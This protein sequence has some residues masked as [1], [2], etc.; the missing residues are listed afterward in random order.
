MRFGDTSNMPGRPAGRFMPWFV[1]V[2]GGCVLAGSATGQI[3]CTDFESPTFVGSG[4]GTTIN[5]QDSWFTPAVAGSIDGLV[6]TEGKNAFAIPRNPTGGNQFLGGRS[7]GATF[8]RAQRE[9]ITFPDVTVIT[10]DAVAAAY[11]GTLPTA[12]NLGSFSLAPEPNPAAPIIRTYIQLNTWV[13]LAAATTWNAGYLPYNALGVQAAQPGLFPGPEWQN[14]PIDTW[15]RFS[16]TLDFTLNRITSVSITNL[17]S[18]VT[19]T[20]EPVDWF[21][22]G[23]QA[24]VLLRPT[25]VRFF[26]GGAAGNTMGYDNLCVGTPPGPE[27]PCDWNDDDFL[28]SQDFFD[29]LSAFFAGEADFNADGFTNSQDFF[30]FLSCFFAPP[31][32]C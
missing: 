4:G 19:T 8:V 18:G 1:G 26:V 14:L 6:F 7:G 32:G 5:G 11:A 9:G 10:Y 22:G 27:C 31:T 15:F 16:T 2:V 24:S 12:Q 13:D 3:F 20:A 30:D 25:G 21:L 28:N 17:S 23:G 29:F